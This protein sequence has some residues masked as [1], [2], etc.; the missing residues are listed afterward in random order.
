MISL[1]NP[2][3]KDATRVYGQL[4]REI[5]Y[6]RDNKQ[7]AV[8]DLEINWTDLEIHHLNEHQNG[9]QTTMENG[10]KKKNKKNY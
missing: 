9:G 5:I 6:Y 1:L 2:I 4:E 3:R 8:C 10:L 7:C